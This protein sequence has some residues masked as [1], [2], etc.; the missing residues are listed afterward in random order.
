MEWLLAMREPLSPSSSRVKGSRVQGPGSRAWGSEVKILV[1]TVAML[2]TL[3][4]LRP[5]RILRRTAPHSLSTHVRPEARGV[6]TAS[7]ISTRVTSH[8]PDA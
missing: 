4:Q 6:T 7:T 2:A 8:N 3:D 5:H 1:P